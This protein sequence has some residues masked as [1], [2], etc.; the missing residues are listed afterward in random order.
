MNKTQW[1]SIYA[2]SALRG[3]MDD[4]DWHTENLKSSEARNHPDVQYALLGLSQI[5]DRAERAVKNINI[6]ED[7]M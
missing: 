6:A 5:R 2:V 4:V 1:Q 3:V 7:D